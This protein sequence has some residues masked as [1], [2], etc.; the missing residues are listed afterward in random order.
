MP[1]HLR[2]DYAWY[3]AANVPPMGY[4]IPSPPQTSLRRAVNLLW[5]VGPADDDTEVGA[6]AR[7]SGATVSAMGYDAQKRNGN[8]GDD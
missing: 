6:F 1:Q 8:G 5:P 7:G 4:D 2:C 3:A